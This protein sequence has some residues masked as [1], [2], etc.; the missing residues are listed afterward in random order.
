MRVLLVG[1]N[2]DIDTSKEMKNKV[3]YLPP[4]LPLFPE[5]EEYEPDFPL[6]PEEDEDQSVCKMRVK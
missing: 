6:F 2:M 4:L 3:V 1:M 5:L